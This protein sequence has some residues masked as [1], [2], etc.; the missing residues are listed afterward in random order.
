MNTDIRL[1]VNF[2]THPKTVK[3][4]RQLGL[5]GVVSLLRLWL[6]TAQNR[7]GGA[8]SGMDVDDIE[9]AAGW[10]GEQGA[11]VSTVT[12]LRLLDVI[13]EGHRLHDWEEHNP[14]QSEAES[15]ADKGRFSRLRQICPEEYERLKDKGINAISKAEYSRM[16][17][18]RRISSEVPATPGDAMAIAGVPPENPT[19]KTGVPQSTL[20]VCPRPSPS[21]S[22]T[23]GPDPFQAQPLSSPVPDPALNVK[24]EIFLSEP[25]GTD[26]QSGT[27]PEEVPDA[28]QEKRQAKKK[29]EPL[30]EDSEPYR[31]AV[32]MRDTLRANVPTLKEPDLQKWAQTFDVALRN[33]ERMKDVRF[34]AQVIK[35]ACSESFWRANIQSPGK[36]REKFDQL[37]A[38]ME[39]ESAKARTAPQQS[40][41]KSPAQRRLE[42]NQQAGRDAKRLL[43]GEQ[44]TQEVTH[45]A[46]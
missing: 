22:P 28:S 14:W 35:W 8:L 25:C 10:Q 33:D 23:P 17:S 37:T 9:I 7:P 2:F 19:G 32:F 11:F 30:P 13:G 29:P 27:H 44:A 12:S 24:K 5:E 41:W 6:W 18:A 36:L 15:R 31:L 43:F 34:V 20:G 16:T 4:I 40:A 26:A 45:D 42:S 46:G 3:L 21:P 39:S 38:K 1:S